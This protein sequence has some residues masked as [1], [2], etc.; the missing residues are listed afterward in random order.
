MARTQPCSFSIAHAFPFLRNDERKTQNN[1]S[2]RHDHNLKVI[3]YDYQQKLS[4]KE[5]VYDRR[6]QDIGA[7]INVALVA[8]E[9]EKVQ[10][11]SRRE[12]ATT[13]AEENA[14][15]QLQRANADLNVVTVKAKEEIAQLLGKTNSN[16]ESEK[17]KANKEHE[18]EIFES[19]ERIKMAD[20]HSN[21][22][23]TTAKAEGDSAAALKVIREHNLQMAKLEVL[24]FP[25][26]SELE[27]V[28]VISR[29]STRR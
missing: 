13:K 7:D 9:R 29:V 11:E 3:D 16:A 4:E 2:P 15:I 24:F 19:Q 18:I 27:K 21:A 5:R 20:A 26:F 10:A 8:R 1:P 17:I 14:Q 25:F 28:Q 6:L 23:K 22:L 12:V